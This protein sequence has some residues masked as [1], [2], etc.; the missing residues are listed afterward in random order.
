MKRTILILTLT[1]PIAQLTYAMEKNIPALNNPVKTLS[2]DIKKTIRKIN[3]KFKGNK[4]DIEKY[5]NLKFSYNAATAIKLAKEYYYIFGKTHNLNRMI[6][7]NNLAKY[8]KSEFLNIDQEY[9]FSIK[10]LM[11]NHK[12]PEIYTCYELKALDLSNLKIDSLDGLSLLNNSE[13]IQYLFLDHNQITSINGEYFKNLSNLKHFYLNDNKI[14]KINIANFICLKELFN[15][16]L[17]NNALS[18]ELRLKLS[19]YFNGKAL[20]TI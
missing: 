13:E 5:I 6:D 19:Q 8:R 7:Y 20:L 9:G 11:D 16:N 18:D 12:L 10:E 14:D 17:N 3:E 15:I 1:L 2:I 4:E